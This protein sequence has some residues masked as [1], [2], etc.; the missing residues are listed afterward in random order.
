MAA[1]ISHFCNY[2]G[3]HLTL[4][5]LI[6]YSH[7]IQTHRDVLGD[8]MVSFLCQFAWPTGCPK[9]I[10]NVSSGCVWSV[11]MMRLALKSVDAVKNTAL[12]SVGGCHSVCPGEQKVGEEDYATF[13]LPCCGAGTS[14]LIFPC[15]WTGIYIIDCPHFLAFRLRLNDLTGFPESP[16]LIE[17]R[18]L[19]VSQPPIIV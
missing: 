8:V 6:K 7:K 3:P 11:S 13:L 4:A 12:L 14:H 15:P 10:L 5:L 18:F 1:F 17:D 2:S 9:S 19:G 16:G